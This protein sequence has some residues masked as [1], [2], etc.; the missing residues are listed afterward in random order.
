VYERIGGFCP[1]AG[2]AFDWE[3]WKRMAVHYPVWYD[4]R[5]LACF[6]QHPASESFDLIRT[7]QQIADTRRAIAISHT[8]LPTDV[9]EKLSQSAKNH[10]ALYALRL[11][12][13]QF[14]AGE[15]ES[16]LANI[17]EGLICSQW[18]LV[19]RALMT[20]LAKIR[21]KANAT[22]MNKLVATD[23]S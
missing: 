10:Y 9:A 21:Q 11:A 15:Y 3:M 19:L 2:S 23:Q 6:R 18:G 20:L 16:A 7:G 22:T 1:Q 14:E 8:Y 4:P 17:H 12:E 13:Q 5:P